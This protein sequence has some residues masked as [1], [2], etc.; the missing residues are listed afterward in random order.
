M[1]TDS[2][3]CLWDRV[4]QLCC[5]VQAVDFAALRAS[6]ISLDNQEWWSNAAS[7][8]GALQTA[9]RLARSVLAHRR[10]VA[11]ELGTPESR[12]DVSVSLLT[13]A[14]IEEARGELDA[15]M[16][17]YEE[18]LAIH[19]LFAKELGTPESLRDVS[20]SLRTV[21]GIEEARGDR[22]AAMAKYEESL[23]I[24]RLLA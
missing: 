9:E 15:A 22:D 6:V 21:A 14:G 1:I 13:V 3:D 18:S 8:S 11:K 23:A 4:R 2:R 17:K 5:V 24:H 16:A 7:T 19:R 10:G 12:R 20:V